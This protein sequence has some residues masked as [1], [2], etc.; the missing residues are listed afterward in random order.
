MAFIGVGLAI[1]G[2]SFAHV[3]GAYIAMLGIFG[4]CLRWEI[5]QND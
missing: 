4:F 5:Q 3:D 1:L 2:M